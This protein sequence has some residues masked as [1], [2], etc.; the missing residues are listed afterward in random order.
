MKNNILLLIALFSFHFLSSQST[1]Q[2]LGKWKLESVEM[3]KQKF[4]P[5]QMFETDEIYQIFREDKT[6]TSIVGKAKMEGTWEEDKK[7]KAILLSMKNG[8]KQSMKII[9]ISPKQR[10]V[11]M[12]ELILNYIKQD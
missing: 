10:T 4:E 11:Q 2:L 9:S 8:E 1:Q 5:S 12:K 3:Q 6:F 7:S